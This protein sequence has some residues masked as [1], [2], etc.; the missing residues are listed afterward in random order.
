MTVQTVVWVEAGLGAMLV[1][2]AAQLT[3]SRYKLRVRVDRLDAE[4]KRLWDRVHDAGITYVYTFDPK[5]Y[6]TALVGD[7]GAVAGYRAG[8]ELPVPP[9]RIFVDDVEFLTSLYEKTDDADDG[10]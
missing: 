4:V 2:F 6:G 1:L 8:T 3:R 9:A 10:G 5:A 7:D